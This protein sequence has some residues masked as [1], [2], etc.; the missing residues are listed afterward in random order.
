MIPTTF[1]SGDSMKK[2]RISAGDRNSMDS[3]A[4]LLLIACPH[5]FRMNFPYGAVIKK[6]ITKTR[7]EKAKIAISE[8]LYKIS[9]KVKFM[10]ACHSPE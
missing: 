6:R 1:L 10:A 2:N 3:H 5:P 7:T 4:H 8:Y 9:I